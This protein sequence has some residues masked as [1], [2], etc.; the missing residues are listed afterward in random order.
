MKTLFSILLASTAALAC[1]ASEGPLTLT[2]KSD[3][4]LLLTGGLR[5]AIIQIE[6]QAAKA[7]QKR[8]TPINLALVLDRSGSMAGPK[9]EKAKQ[10]AVVALEGLGADD[11]FSLVVYDDEAE[12]LIPAQK[13]EDT[14]ALKKA[15]RAIQEGGSTALHAGV[16]KGATQ[17]RKYFDREKVN[18]VIL[19]SDGL[20]NV[21]PS[22]P[23]DL[24]K[25]GKELRAEGMSV[26]TVGLG[27][28]YN[29]DLMTALAEASRGNYYYVQDVEKLP[30]IFKDELGSI[31]S[32]VARNVKIRITLPA[33]VKAREVL[34]EDEFVFQ[35]QTLTIPLS[36][37]FGSQTRRFLISCE[38]PAG[39]AEKIDL[40]R[41]EL[42]YDDIASGKSE[43]QDRSVQVGQTNDAKAAEASRQID[44]LSNVAI[45][46]NFMAKVRAVKLADE[47]QAK[48][49][50]AVLHQQLSINASLPAGVLSDSLK[51]DAAELER[52]A[53]EL[54]SEGQLSKTSRKEM[55]IQ[56]Y[57]D[58]NQK[59]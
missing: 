20:A 12:V 18:R 57:R 6:L 14:T 26:S 1:A 43:Q 23:Q 15:I 51:V 41:V 35:N 9:L 40:A 5:N 21:G 53:K 58:K 4:D 31:K 38:A 56:N 16:E 42:T 13:V 8:T 36:E 24:S 33:G 50:A 28:D 45:S 55:Q 59:N 25:L 47:G 11:M 48:E 37:F 29:E 44:V 39:A 49:A 19:L 22:R 52:K 27:A 3:R 17:L 10:A 2:A 32:V 54:L 46:R 34:G 30:G 7:D